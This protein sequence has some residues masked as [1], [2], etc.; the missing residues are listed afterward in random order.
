MMDT[1]IFRAEAAL[2]LD[3][4]LWV[5]YQLGCSA[6]AVMCANLRG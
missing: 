6:I 1:G 2:E 5:C 4:Y 3:S